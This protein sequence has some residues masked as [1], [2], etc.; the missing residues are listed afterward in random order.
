M[1][2]S[3]TRGEIRHNHHLN[4]QARPPGKMLGSLTSSGLGVVLLP[5]KS[6]LLPFS[7]DV[8]DQILSQV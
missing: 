2:A 4:H 8:L 7:V 5:G 3:G 1:T 6:R